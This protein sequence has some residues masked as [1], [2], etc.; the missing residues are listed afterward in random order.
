MAS[1]KRVS[2]AKGLRPL[3]VDLEDLL[4]PAIVDEIDR[5][6]KLSN[7]LT[8]DYNLDAD[9]SK[10]TTTITFFAKTKDK[11]P[12]E[13]VVKDILEVVEDNILE[14]SHKDFNIEVIWDK[15][16]KFTTG[17]L[18][19]NIKDGDV[20]KHKLKYG[21]KPEAG[22]KASL[23]EVTAQECLQAVGCA[24]LQEN[25]SIDVDDF[26]GFLSYAHEIAIKNG[27][28][29]ENDAKWGA[30]LKAVKKYTDFGNKVEKQRADVYAFG[31]GDKDWVQSTVSCAKA[32]KSKFNGGT[33]TF[34]YPSSDGIMKWWA[35]TYKAAKEQVLKKNGVFADHGIDAGMLD[36]NKWNPADIFAVNTDFHTPIFTDLKIDNRNETQQVTPS[37]LSYHMK[38]LTN[39]KR[40]GVINI[41]DKIKKDAENA[42]TV[43]GLPSLNQWLLNQ[44]NNGNLYPISL[45]KAGKSANVTIINDNEHDV[46]MEA[47][48]ESVEWRDD[49]R[50]RATNKVE[51]HFKIDV[52]GKEKDYFINA[53][54]FNE[55]Q[56]IKLQIEQVG[57]LAFHG[58]VGLSIASLIINHTDQR[59]KQKLI[60]VRNMKKLKDAGMKNSNKLFSSVKGIEGMWKATKDEDGV[61]QVLLD[62]VGFLSKK[63]VTKIPKTGSGHVSK[64]QATE[65]GYIIKRAEANKLVSEILYALFTFAGSRGLVLFDK[66]DFKNHFA[67]S[68]HLKV[69]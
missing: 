50:G 19:V 42:S 20:V 49:F 47:T 57:A 14:I 59:I 32:L 69:Q 65:F 4:T 9:S 66:N 31:I 37:A 58:K 16:T 21:I 35:P 60:N 11:A 10:K 68:V 62:Y 34:V 46:T 17:F 15:D 1:Q 51:V 22:A 27:S 56:D 5:N 12:R 55:G 8:G 41:G 67:S 28:T 6:S 53:R 61:S 7:V 63:G 36:I 18:G 13:Q 38:D 26:F 40:S 29:K 54:Q 30:A 3:V 48:L 64:V 33:Y 25:N 43:E 24:Y 52:D 45:K 2:G 39:G 23:Y 44:V